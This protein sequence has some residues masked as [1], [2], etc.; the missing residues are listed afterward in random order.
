MA[1][2]V[3]SKKQRR[4]RTWPQRLTITAAVLA[5][6]ACFAAAGGI[7]AGQQV[8]EDRKLSPE[9]VDPSTGETGLEAS[10]TGGADAASG[11]GAASA[12]TPD[13]TD[14]PP[15]TFPTADPDARNFLITG[16]DNNSCIDPDSPYA[17]AF[18]DRSAFGERSD[19]IM[20]LRVNPTTNQAAVLS[21][22]RDLWVTI[23]G[24][25]GQQRI[26][27]AYERDNPQKLIDTLYA[28]F[29]LLVDHTIQIDFCAFKTLVDAVDG[30]DV[31]FE[32][33]VRDER[34]G[35]NV[36]E[37]GCFTF[38]GD[39]A[40]AYARSRYMQS[41]VDGEWVTDGTSDLG[42][43]S[44]QQDF[45]R[46]VLQQVRSAGFFDPD[47]IGA[48]LET[49]LKYLVTDPGLTPDRM[50]EFAGVMANVDP[51]QLTTYQ[52]EARGDTVQGQSVLIPRIDGDNMQAILQ[53]FRGQATLA[54]GLEQQFEEDTFVEADDN[55]LATTPAVPV[56]DASDDA[57]ATA[58]E[59]APGT[60]VPS[61]QAD[62]N[63]YGVVPDA[64]TTCG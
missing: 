35:L 33:P 55:P 52:I 61:I 17:P 16:A 39:H 57:P 27:V 29:G 64:A 30:V 38:D 34:T 60:T 41:F 31:P 47:V 26:N 3:D 50:L 24:R 62:Q 23:P 56:F 15:A 4:R 11:D 58:V 53:I 9:I 22:P 21:F 46:R 14:G 59:V 5:A 1:A 51:T 8:L 63:T 40:L 12:D 37:P 42:R 25:T 2:G 32:T 43:I 13:A 28:N 45:L 48:L 20:L 19:T 18:G 36:P 54:D 44:R 49:N 7:Y 10:A 6:M